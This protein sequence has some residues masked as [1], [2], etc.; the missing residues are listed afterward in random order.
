MDSVF[1]VIEKVIPGNR[2]H[3]KRILTSGKKLNIK[4]GVDPTGNDLHFGH[5]VNFWLLRHFQEMGHKIILLIGDITAQIGDPTGMNTERPELNGNIINK[6]ADKFIK[7]VKQILLFDDDLLA[8]R[9]NSEWYEKMN[10]VKFINEVLRPITI[11]KLTERKTFRNRMEQGLS[12]HA[13]ELI[14]QLLQGYDSVEL[15]ADIALCGDDQL[16]NE[17]FGRYYQEKFNIEPQY[18]ITTKLTPGIDGDKKQSKSIGNY[19]GLEHTVEEKLRRIMSIPDNLIH[20]YFEIYTNLSDEEIKTKEDVV[21]DQRT[22]KINLAEN[23]LVRY[24]TDK[25]IKNAIKSYE[26]TATGGAPGDIETFYVQRMEIDLITFA[27]ENLGMSKSHFKRL[28]KGNAVKLD[29][30]TIRDGECDNDGKMFVDISASPVLRYGKNK[31][32]KIEQ[33]KKC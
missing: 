25:E 32:C 22:L 31:W 10:S 16:T 7:Q 33:S 2:E 29:D 21:R 17:G 6:N 4:F 20:Q 18:I 9:Y 24:H 26:I 1:R 27:N 19:I 12:I 5:A 28:I 3:L 11:S 8:I 13:H 15:K 14:Y 30:R 23:M